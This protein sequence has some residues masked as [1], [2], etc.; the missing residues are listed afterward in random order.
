LLRSNP[1]KPPQEGPAQ[2]VEPIYVMP[3]SD[4]EAA[5]A[6]L[7][8]FSGGGTRIE[9]FTYI[10]NMNVENYHAGPPPDAGTGKQLEADELAKFGREF[11]AAASELR[12]EVE[13]IARILRS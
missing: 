10:A 2:V 13:D 7:Q 3:R 11:K 12:A 8:Q 4:Y 9:N 5:Q 1:E 6:A